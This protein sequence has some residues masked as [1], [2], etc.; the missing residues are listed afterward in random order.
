SV[1]ARVQLIKTL[2]F[3]DALFVSANCPKT[4]EMLR[5]LA[6]E[7]VKDGKYDENAGLMPQRSV[8]LHPFDAL[9]YP[10]FKFMTNP[11]SFNL[12]VGKSDAKPT[13]FFAGSG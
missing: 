7:R 11:A 2:L 13:A 10:I 4:V 12:R 3:D 9:S 6:S 1:P 5:L 8:Y